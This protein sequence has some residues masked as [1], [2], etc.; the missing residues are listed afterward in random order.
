MV[1]DEN[2]QI[3]KLTA[4]SGYCILTATSLNFQKEVTKEEWD[5]VFNALTKMGKSVSFWIGDCLAYRKQKWG[6][7]VDI[8]ESTGLDKQ[9]LADYKWTSESV[10]SSLRKEDLS[11]NHH[12]EV[13]KLSEEKQIEFLTRASEEKLTVRELRQEIK[14]DNIVT[15][16]FALPTGTFN[17]IYCDPP[18]QYDFAE[19]DNRKIENQYPTMTVEEIC[20]IELPEISEDA[21]L[22]MWATSPKLCEALK[23]IEAWGFNYRTHSVWDK[24]K[25]GMGYW[26]RGQHELLLVAVKGEFSPPDV[27]FRNSSIYREAR[28]AHSSKPIFFYEWIEKAFEGNKIE[29]FARNKRIGWE[30]WGNELN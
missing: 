30:A 20:K 21:L 4:I 2:T 22:L 26:F 24:E 25:I 19:T 1:L 12:K 27:Q 14:K 3:E 7:Y 5:L 28:Q 10:E 17:I 8:I 6:M 13:A 9:T 11:F 16:T 29:L 18:W 23:V 15:E